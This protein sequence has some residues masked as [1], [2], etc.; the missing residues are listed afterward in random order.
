M[1]QIF[2]TGQIKLIKHIKM[3]LIWQIL[4]HVYLFIIYKAFNIEVNSRSNI[5]NLNRTL[6]RIKINKLE[7]L[8]A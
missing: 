4:G 5:L 1:Y 7:E 8:V 3:S 2:K 6:Q